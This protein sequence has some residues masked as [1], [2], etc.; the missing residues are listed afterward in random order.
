MQQALAGIL[1]VHLN[2]ATGLRAADVSLPC[3]FPHCIRMFGSLLHAACLRPLH[4]RLPLHGKGDTYAVPPQLW[5]SSDPYCVLSVGESA[6]RS[7]T[8][9][10][11]LEPNWDEHFQLYVRCA[12]VSSLTAVASMETCCSQRT[13][14]PAAYMHG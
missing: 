12:P 3:L 14:V 2:G 5:G 8:V 11:C 6:R 10:R 7:A 13:C 9:P 4:C 1:E